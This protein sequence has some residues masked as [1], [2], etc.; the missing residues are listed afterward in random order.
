M[1]GWFRCL[2][3]D[4]AEESCCEVVALDHG[5]EL[6]EA[7]GEPACCGWTRSFLPIMVNELAGAAL[8][9]VVAPFRTGD[10]QD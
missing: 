2:P 9:P 4:R 5:A 3:G 1:N 6:A 10:V 8:P 7:V